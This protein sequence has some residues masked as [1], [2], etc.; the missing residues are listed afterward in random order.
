MQW[1]A[2]I[3]RRSNNAYHIIVLTIKSAQNATGQNQEW[4]KTASKKVNEAVHSLHSWL[5]ISFCTLFNT[6]GYPVIRIL[7]RKCVTEI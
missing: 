4:T 3:L 2:C 5:I 6:Y 1:H 7:V